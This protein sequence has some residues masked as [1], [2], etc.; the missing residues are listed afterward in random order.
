M[1]PHAQLFQGNTCDFLKKLQN[2]GSAETSLE[3]CEV[4]ESLSMVEQA[5]DM[6]QSS[7]RGRSGSGKGKCKARARSNSGS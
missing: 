5:R 2:S 7:G 3:M 4:K 1:S 6:T